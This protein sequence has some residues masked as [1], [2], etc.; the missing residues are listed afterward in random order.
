LLIKQRDEHADPSWNVE[1]SRLARSVLT[2]RSLK[3]IEQ[4][5]LEGKSRRV[6]TYA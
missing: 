4:I 3:E 1:S 2:G 5:R 6:R